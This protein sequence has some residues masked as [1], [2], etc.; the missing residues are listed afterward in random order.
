M[1]KLAKLGT[2]FKYS[3]GEKQPSI[4]V[5]DKNFDPTTQELGR[6]ASIVSNSNKSYNLKTI[7]PRPNNSY[8]VHGVGSS[9][10]MNRKNGV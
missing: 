3:K 8:S 7:A 5:Y 2:N 9:S 10:K 1:I 4:I 6:N